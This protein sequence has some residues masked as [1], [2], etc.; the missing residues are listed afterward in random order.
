MKWSLMI[1]TNPAVQT[2]SISSNFGAA[3]LR[4]HEVTKYF[5][6]TRRTK[7]TAPQSKH[8]NDDLFHSPI[9][10]FESLAFKPPIF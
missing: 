5:K 2:L 6:E 7:T 9:F 4:L 10:R 1:G 8:K 3:V